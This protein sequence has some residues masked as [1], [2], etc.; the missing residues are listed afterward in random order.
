MIFCDFELYLAFFA[1][2]S[3]DQLIWRSPAGSLFRAAVASPLF[4]SINDYPNWE[5]QWQPPVWQQQ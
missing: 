1:S 5:Q 4:G 3:L 2:F